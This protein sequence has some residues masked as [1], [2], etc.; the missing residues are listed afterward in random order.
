MYNINYRIFSECYLRLHRFRAI[1]I[2]IHKHVQI[3][4]AFLILLHINQI[5]QI[6]RRGIERR[7]LIIFKT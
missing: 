2:I 4:T 3:N 7:Y 5:S 6:Y 1:T